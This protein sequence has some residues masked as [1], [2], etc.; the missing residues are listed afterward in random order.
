MNEEE[1]NIVCLEVSQS[2]LES[3]YNIFGVVVCVP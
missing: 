3:S 2:Q 1:I